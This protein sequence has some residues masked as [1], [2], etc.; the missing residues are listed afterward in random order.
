MT[1]SF[2]FHFAEEICKQHPTLSLCILDYTHFLST[3]HLMK[4]LIFAS[5][6]YFKTLI[7]LNVLQ[8]QNLNSRYLCLKGSL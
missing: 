5:I 3:F 2:H 6:S 7:L 4:L 1:L 8:S